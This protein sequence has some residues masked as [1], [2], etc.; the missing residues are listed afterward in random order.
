MN[1]LLCLGV[2]RD[3]SLI[4]ITSAESRRQNIAF[5]LHT[6]FAC[7]FQVDN[8]FLVIQIILASQQFLYVH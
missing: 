7:C 1:C 3:E 2:E 4:D 6:H 8:R 5:V